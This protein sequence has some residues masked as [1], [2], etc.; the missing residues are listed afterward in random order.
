M[1][2]RPA[3]KPDLD[4]I[5]D[6]IDETLPEIHRMCRVARKQKTKPPTDRLCPEARELMRELSED[7]IVIDD[8][9]HRTR[10]KHING[11]GAA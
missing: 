5:I 6:R 9:D 10:P 3:K 8:Q 7:P 11:S 4:T 2:A 1:P